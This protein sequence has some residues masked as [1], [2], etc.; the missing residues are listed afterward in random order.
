MHPNL[1][2]LA[3]GILVCGCARYRT[4]D[5]PTG[6][7]HRRTSFQERSGLAVAAEIVVDPVNA[8]HHF[9]PDFWHEGFFAAYVSFENRGSAS[10][11]IER[12]DFAV[13][14]ESGGR[15]APIAPR[16]VFDD[17]RRAPFN[18]LTAL[19]SPLV[20]PALLEYRSVEEYNFGLARGLDLKSFPTSVR[21]EPGDPP[22]CRA[23]YFR[24]V[25]GE[26]P[27]PAAFDSSV[28]EFTVQAEGSAS[29]PDEEAPPRTEGEPPQRVLGK[30]VPFT[31]TLARE[32]MP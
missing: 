3:V 7:A 1:R 22:L 27:S 19:L 20:I 2:L 24:A 30:K 21:L 13:I 15:F 28:L 10:F 8:E 11:E 5:L 32:D 17:L 16:Q 9:G 23:L 4:Y 18:G 6:P 12:K 31:V 26:T 25:H 14:L 29:G